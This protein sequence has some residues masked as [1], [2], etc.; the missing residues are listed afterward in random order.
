[1][2]FIGYLVLNVFL[3]IKTKVNSTNIILCVIKGDNPHFS[4][5]HTPKCRIEG[6]IVKPHMVIEHINGSLDYW[7]GH[8]KTESTPRYGKQAERRG[9][10]WLHTGQGIGQD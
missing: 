6:Y 3:L 2:L 7:F 10:Y 5:I 9:Q 8:V 4:K 1:L